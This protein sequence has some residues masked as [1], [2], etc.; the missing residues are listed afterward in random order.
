M[1]R[2]TQA[3]S[4]AMVSRVT[5]ARQLPPEL[6][7]QIV[8]KTDGVALFVEE[9][10][11]AVL[12]SGTLKQ[13]GDRYEYSGST[14]SVTIPA[15]LRDS[16]MARLDRSLS[17]QGGRA[18]RR[19]NRPRVQLRADLGGCAQRQ[20]HSSMSRWSSL[21]ESGLVFRRGV[22]PDAVFTFKHALVRDA[23]YDTLLKSR[24]KELHGRIARVLE[25]RFPATADAEPELLAYHLTEAVQTE[26]A[27][28]YWCKAG[29]L[30]LR[31]MALTEA[32]SHLTKGLEL[33]ATLPPSASA[34]LGSWTCAYRWAWP[35]W[36]CADGTRT[37]W[38]RPLRRRWSWQRHC[39]VARRCFLF[40][41]GC[42]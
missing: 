22:L 8:A 9:L 21:T 30:A 31:R 37:R 36:R 38:P 23:A 14:A 18:D 40:S 7:E 25:E 1:S 10:T 42:G 29:E 15:T 27:I 2:L 33:V 6:V 3:Q 4:S 24:R 17:G 26:R 35:G 28:G 16:L 41:P 13:V 19:R 32:I 20:E 5:G 11:K 39:T 12:E 34:M